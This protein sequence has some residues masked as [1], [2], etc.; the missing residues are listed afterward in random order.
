MPNIKDIPLSGLLTFQ[1]VI[2]FGS[3]EISKLFFE[4]LDAHQK[5]K[6]SSVWFEELEKDFEERLAYNNR[7]T[8]ICGKE[9]RRRMKT[10]FPKI[11]YPLTVHTYREKY[12]KELK[13]RNNGVIPLDLG[14][15]K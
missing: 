2:E 14:Q 12:E 8:D 6:I 15:D 1:Q 5:K 4:A 3:S 10:L 11:T 7:C 9:I 13:K